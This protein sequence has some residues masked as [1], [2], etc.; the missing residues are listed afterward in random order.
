M[1][2]PTLFSFS[3]RLGIVFIVESASLSAIAVASLLLYI[4]A[5][6][7]QLCSLCLY[8]PE[9]SSTQSYIGDGLWKHTL[10]ITL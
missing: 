8:L 10:T 7:K 5:S 1:A 3:T 2:E 9:S 6:R 4:L